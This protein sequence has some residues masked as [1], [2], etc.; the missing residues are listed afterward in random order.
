MIMM[1]PKVLLRY[2][3]TFLIPLVL[4]LNLNL[5]EKV[6]AKTTVSREIGSAAFM[7]VAHTIDANGAFIP[8]FTHITFSNFPD[9]I[10]GGSIDLSG[11]TSVLG[12]DASRTWIAGD[13]ITSILKLGDL[14]GA[15]NL[16]IRP[17]LSIL[18]AVGLPLDNLS[19]GDFGGILNNQ[20]IGTLVAAIPQLTHFSLASIV[21]LYDLVAKTFGLS[22]VES[23]AQSTIGD[24]LQNTGRGEAL[25][26]LHLDQL[27]L[28]GYSLDSI[29]GLINGPLEQFAKW[30]DALIGDIPGLSDLP[31]SS[32][33]QD[34]TTDGIFANLDIVFGNKEGYRTNTV[35]GSTVV[36]FRYPCNQS[37]CAHI[38]LQPT[39][40]LPLPTLKGKQWI[41]G[42]SQWVPG[43]SGCL[44]G[45]EPTG[46]HPFSK[47]FKVVLTNTDEAAG[48]AEFGIYFHFSFFCGTTPYVIGPFPWMSQYEKDLIFLGLT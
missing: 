34:L 40:F 6:L 27:N 23:L 22:T 45:E 48:R 15:S 38:E 21:P 30:E 1:L 3:A 43:G 18:N 29:P 41:S 28:A 33:F 44:A 32:I 10:A 4:V 39:S 2:F 25:S 42:N 19:L 31:L 11:L 17:L 20:T 46:R 9:V 8:D 7:Y 37:N 47:A 36:G 5:P 14:A 13:A 26:N 16:P 24:L 12:Y 35:S